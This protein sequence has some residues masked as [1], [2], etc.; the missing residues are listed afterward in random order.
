MFEQL[1][2]V[3]GAGLSLWASKEKTKYVDR[4]MELKRDYY[5]EFNKDPAVRSDAVLDNLKRE[6]CILADAFTTSV[7]AANTPPKP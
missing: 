1:L 5:A 3:L 6:L 2:G 7:G 4:L